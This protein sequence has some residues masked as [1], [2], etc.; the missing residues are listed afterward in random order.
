MAG[1]PRGATVPCA[2]TGSAWIAS[3]IVRHESGEIA[4]TLIAPRG[5]GAAE[6][7]RFP[8]PLRVTGDGPVA[9]D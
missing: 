1:L 4:L 6:A 9:L 7:Q 2:E 5:A 8:P 3:D